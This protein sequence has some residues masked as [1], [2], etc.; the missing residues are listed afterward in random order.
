[1]VSVSV[2]L[3]G[4][5]IWRVRITMKIPDLVLAALLCTG[6]RGGLW[7]DRPGPFR[8]CAAACDAAGDR[9]AAAARGAAGG[10]VAGG[11]AA[12]GGAADDD[13]AAAVA[14]GGGAAAAGAVADGGDG[15]AAAAVGGGGGG[16]EVSAA[17][18]CSETTSPSW[19]QR[20]SHAQKYLV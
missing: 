5:F 17:G 6:W 9:N 18:R 10:A 11:A 4:A 13:A 19:A 20:C 16:G 12:G 2:T 15:G 3:I 1:M 8:D 14:G 7:S